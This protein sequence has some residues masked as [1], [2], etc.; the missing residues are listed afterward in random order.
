MR[1]REI[2]SSVEH[3]A[4][5]QVDLEVTRVQVRQSHAIIA[6]TWRFIKEFDKVV[7]TGTM[8]AAPKDPPLA[9]PK[10]DRR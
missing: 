4:V 2:L 5:L 1:K 3:L 6:D 9:A 7:N 8:I 10:P